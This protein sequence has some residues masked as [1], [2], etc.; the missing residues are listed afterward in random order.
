MTN[1]ELVAALW[2]L[3]PSLPVVLRI[4]DPSLC[5]CACEVTVAAQEAS[6]IPADGAIIAKGGAVVL[7]AAPPPIEGV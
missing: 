7:T 2:S 1:A 3:P 6:F 5:G 4:A